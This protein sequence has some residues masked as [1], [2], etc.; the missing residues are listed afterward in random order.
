LVW[1]ISTTVFTTFLLMAIGG[2]VSAN[3]RQLAQK[4]GWDTWLVWLDDQLPRWAHIMLA[5]WAPLRQKWW[6]WF[7]L[8]LSGGISGAL[9]L[10][11]NSSPLSHPKA[12]V[13]NIIPEKPPN[14]DATQATAPNLTPAE[15]ATSLDIWNRL[16]NDCINPLKNIHNGLDATLKDWT[17]L[18]RTSRSAFISSLIDTS[19]SLGDADNCIETLRDEHPSY[20]DTSEILSQPYIN[21]TQKA[22]KRLIGAMNDLPQELPDN[23]RRLSQY[24]GELRVEMTSLA[25]WAT[26]AGRIANLK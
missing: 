14:R 4:R 13:S 23:D 15:R 2:L 1:T 17:R 9:W 10:V 20:K 11:P 3:V 6:L 26:D 18:V 12:S 21:L 25:N 8:G 24:V 16:N 19:N 5:A 22:I 7:A